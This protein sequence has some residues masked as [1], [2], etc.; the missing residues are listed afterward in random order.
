MNS[1]TL[2]FSIPTPAVFKFYNN[3]VM[4][5]SFDQSGYANLGANS[6]YNTYGLRIAGWDYGN[7]V[8]Q[9]HLAYPYGNIG[10]SV[11]NSACSVNSVIGGTIK[12]SVNSSG[13]VVNGSI[14]LA[15][16]IW[17]NSANGV[18][19]FWFDTNGR[20]YFHEAGNTGYTFRNTAQGDIVT[21]DD[22]GNVAAS[23]LT[24]GR[25]MKA[26]LYHYYQP[27]LYIIARLLQHHFKLKQ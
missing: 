23:T 19:R 3:G 8:H 9:Q 17:P 5:Q 4:T 26:N 25:S 18:N 11:G 24:L 1:S 7:T 21:I 10:I 2:W 14:T 22:G 12:T 20:T 6:S 15:N 27:N 13:L 16:G